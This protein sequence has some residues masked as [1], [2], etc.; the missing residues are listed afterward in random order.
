MSVDQ[1]PVIKIVLSVGVLDASF[2]CP[3]IKESKG[4]SQAIKIEPAVSLHHYEFFASGL[5]HDTFGPIKQ[6]QEATWR[7]L[8]LRSGIE[9]IYPL[10][11]SKP[12]L[13]ILQHMTPG[14]QSDPHHWDAFFP[15]PD[16]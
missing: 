12:I 8:V 1:P 2:E 16:A 4:L 6:E 7:T 11:A 15:L 10:N 9:N 5:S 3:S 14:A 13:N